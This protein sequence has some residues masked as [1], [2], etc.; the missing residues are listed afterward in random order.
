MGESTTEGR[1]WEIDVPLLT[2]RHMLGALAKAMLGSAAVV[3]LLVGLLLGI[4]GQWEAVPPLAG[5]LLAIGGALFLVGLA[6]MAF[7]FRNRIRT[8]FT[9]DATGVK[10]RTTDKVVR[11][12]NRGSF[13][14]GLVLGS[15]AAAGSGLLAAT[16]ENQGLR[17]SGAFRAVPEPATR[18]IAFRNGWRTLLRIYCTP[19]AY[20]ETVALVQEQMQRHGTA[21]RCAGGSPVGSYLGRT[22]LVVVATLPVFLV[23]DTYGFNLLPPLLLLCFGI[24]TVWF[25]RPLAWVVLVLELGI[26][27]MALLG[28]LAQRTSAYRH[29]VYRRYETISGD[30]WAL[31]ALAAA[32]MLALAWLAMAT[33]RRRILPALEADLA[34]A[35]E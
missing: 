30:G 32:G 26:V 20:A 33:L 7:P 8:R 5:L 1:D 12:G 35:D 28:A 13:L 14:V 10:M 19:E 11:V 29:E 6:A 34:D 22:A 2:N 17:W 3:I 16:Q 31:T 4:Q 15:G 25:V 18:T 21:G 9:V 23:A 24:A 27:G